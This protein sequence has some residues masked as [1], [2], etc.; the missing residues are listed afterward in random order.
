MLWPITP[1]NISASALLCKAGPL[2]FGASALRSIVM[3]R[4]ASLHAG[5]NRLIIPP[6]GM[7][8]AIWARHCNLVDRVYSHSQITS[9]TQYS[10]AL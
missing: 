8:G 1:L 3:Q 2:H 4:G 9:D 6:L 10:R 5:H 7:P